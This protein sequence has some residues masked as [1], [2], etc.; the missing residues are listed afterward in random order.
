MEIIEKNLNDLKIIEI[1]MNKCNNEFDYTV[2]VR[3]Q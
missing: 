3:K 2:K 1:G